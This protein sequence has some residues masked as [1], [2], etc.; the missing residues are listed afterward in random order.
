MGESVILLQS[1]NQFCCHFLYIIL[2]QSILMHVT[3]VQKLNSYS[4]HLEMH[5]GFVDFEKLSDQLEFWIPHV[6]KTLRN[7]PGWFVLL[8]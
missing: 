6:S 2:L 8:K 4:L 5:N 7:L 1:L 3:N